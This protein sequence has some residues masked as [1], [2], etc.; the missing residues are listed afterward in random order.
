M[1]RQVSVQLKMGD[2]T[3][4]PVDAIVN[5]ANR[6]LLGGGGVDGAIHQAAGPELLRA[7][8]AIRASRPYHEGLDVGDA[9]ATPAFDIDVSWIIHTV[10][11]CIMDYDKEEGKWTAGDTMLQEAFANCLETADR[12]GVESIAFPAISSGIYGWP[13]KDVANAANGAILGTEGSLSYVKY[14]WFYL[15]D[16]NT[17]NAFKDVFLNERAV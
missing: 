5:A 9:V 2:I 7:C 8:Y 4:A 11:P 16:Q 10:G 12:L 3:K 13:L 1:S 6:S 14:V 17:Y 15:F